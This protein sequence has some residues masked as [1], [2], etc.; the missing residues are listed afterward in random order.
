MKALISFAVALA[1]LTSFAEEE[2]SSAIKFD[3][4]ADLRIRQEIMR[5]VPQSYNGGFLG[6][7]KVLKYKN[8]MRFRPDVWAELKLGENWRI[9]GRLTDEFRWGIPDSRGVHKTTFPGEVVLDNLYI[10][11]KGLFDDLI[12]IRVGRQ[13]LVKMYGL[14]H[15]FIDGTAGDGSRTTYADMVNLALHV[16]EDS[17]ID[18]FALY[19]RDR[20]RIR[21]G[22]RRSR[23]TSL[24]G[25]GGDPSPDMDD[26]GFGAI[27][28]SRV[29][30]LDYKLFWIQK[31]TASFRD[32]GNNKHP[33]RQTNLLGTKLV[34]HW[35]ENFSTPLEL[36]SQVGKNGRGE[37]LYGWAAYA[38]F[39][40]KDDAEKS[41]RPF[42]NGGVLFQSGD[43]KV[44]GPARR[45]ED[46]GHHAW[47]PMWYRGT[48]D[49]ETF[50]Y[51]S[52]Y[53][54]GWWSNQINLKTTMGL[55]FGPRHKAQLMMGPMFA[56]ER[57]GVGG[58]NGAYKG[59][60]AQARYDFPILPAD[61]ESGRRF[62][63]FGHVVVE[64]FEPGDYFA[65]DK[66]SYFFRWQVDFK[67]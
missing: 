63:I 34:P 42:V 36:M 11:G 20:E 60:L 18:L 55:I 5:N 57:D 10:E 24:S 31:D 14:D 25:Y 45:L 16:S 43:G 13:D 32:S 17:W 6:T 59:F 38:G 64:V 21:W 54:A 61:K 52:L 12:D 29:E 3:A 35:T 39:D 22:T 47:D 26:W 2:D 58:G 33:R 7:R 15:I 62:E 41:I 19:N 50:L 28:N 27:W 30:M 51:N 40:W 65:T 56:Q 53:G 67:F 9:Y 46:G 44:K 23:N 48:D 66:T 1:A 49:S 4:G 8:H 37:S